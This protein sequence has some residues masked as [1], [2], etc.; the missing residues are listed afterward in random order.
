MLSRRLLRLLDLVVLLLLALQAGSTLLA[1]DLT[2]TTRLLAGALLVIALAG[3]VQWRVS[4]HRIGLAVICATSLL[5]LL[6]TGGSGAGAVMLLAGLALFTLGY[7]SGW[8]LAVAAAHVA[9]MGLAL[10][11]GDR[12]V[13]VQIADLTGGFAIMVVGVLLGQGLRDLAK[14]RNRNAELLGEVRR[15]AIAEQELMLADERSRSAR[16]LHDGL[17]HQLTL[18]VLSLE[19]AERTRSK[20]PDRA[21]E[22]VETAKQTAVEALAHMRRWVRALNPPREESVTGNAAFE[23][24]ARSFSGTGLDVEVTHTGTERELDRGASLFA[25]R[26]VQEGLTNVVRH[27]SARTVRLLLDWQPTT[28]R[29]LLADDGG[30]GADLTPGFGLR[31][32]A[33]RAAVLGGTFHARVGEQGVEIVGEIPLEGA[34]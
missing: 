27:S 21:F 25:L 16:E 17:G 30:T 9:L 33:E 2:S 11:S 7:G 10:P 14:E 24:I 31:S 19:F 23:A 32:L 28:L 26:M 20:D 12:G 18:V 13:A 3:W 1:P 5:G 4:G 8:G 29:L 22:E 6:L 34:R 15:A